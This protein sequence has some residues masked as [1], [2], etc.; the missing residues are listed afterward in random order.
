MLICGFFCRSNRDHYLLVLV[1][2]ALA[3]SIHVRTYVS[4]KFNNQMN[5]DYDTYRGTMFFF[6]SEHYL[7][8]NKL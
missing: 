6:F 2:R 1:M 8:W 3:S 7:V 4:P 5:Y